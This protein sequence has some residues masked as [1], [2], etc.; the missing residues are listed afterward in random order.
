MFL[1]ILNTFTPWSGHQPPTASTP[2]SWSSGQSG[3]SENSPKWFPIPQ[4]IGLD[5]KIKS[6]AGSEEFLNFGH[7]FLDYQFSNGQKWVKNRE[8]QKN[9]GTFIY[10][11]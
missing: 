7:C 5:T 6:L 2:Y 10:P 11:K 4:N 1:G 3:G 9:K 8:N